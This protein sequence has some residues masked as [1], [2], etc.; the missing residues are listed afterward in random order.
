[1]GDYLPPMFG[2]APWGTCS[3]VG[4]EVPATHHV[5]W[6]A[7]VENGLCCDKHMEEARRLWVF[8]AEHE[9]HVAF[10]SHP[11]AKFHLEANECIIPLECIDWDAHASAELTSERAAK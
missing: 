2:A 1:V 10:C 3:R 6:T 4:C 8:Y 5:I 9:Y 7:D 11:Q